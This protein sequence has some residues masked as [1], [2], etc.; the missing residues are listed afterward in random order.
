MLKKTIKY[1]N[2]NG[3][4]KERDCYFNLTESECAELEA[5]EDNSL[6]K[7]MEIVAKDTED[8]EATVRIFKEIILKA[9]GERSADGE[10]FMK[11]P[12]IRN[13]FECSAAFNALFME[14]ATDAD[15]MADFV[16]RVIPKV[17]NTNSGSTDAFK[18]VAN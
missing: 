11:S 14:L 6:S 12:E 9:Y 2:F 17:D 15:K 10:T 3:E 13:K 5:S 4:A 8:K 1:T 16:N 7:K 18:S